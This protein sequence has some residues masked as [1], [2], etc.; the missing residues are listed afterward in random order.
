MQKNNVAVFKKNIG[1]KST[2]ATCNCPA[3]NKWIQYQT[4]KIKYQTKVS[5]FTKDFLLS[6]NKIKS[7]IVKLETIR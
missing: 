4:R 6:M 7:N 5:M 2:C 3:K 1:L